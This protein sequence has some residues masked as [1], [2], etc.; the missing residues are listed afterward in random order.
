Q[1]TAERAVD[2]AAGDAKRVALRVVVTPDAPPPPEVPGTT[3]L[4]GT[5]PAEAD[6]AERARATKRT[7]GWTA[8][9][10]GAAGLLGAGISLGIRQSA[11]GDLNNACPSPH[12]GCPLSL[13]STVSRGQ[14]ASIA[15]DALGI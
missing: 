14:A 4:P 15:F 1:G 8:L 13:Q 6:D 12:V 3:P 7:I 5:P 11:L 2:L 9:G 10:V